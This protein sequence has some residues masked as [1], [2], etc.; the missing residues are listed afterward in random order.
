MFITASAPN[1]RSLGATNGLAQTTVSIARAVGPA[2]SS[3][4]F[5][6]SSQHNLLGGYAVYAVFGGL[7]CAS[8][9]LAKHLPEDA[10]VE[11]EGEDD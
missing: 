9:L 5:A 11:I 3:S 4:I 7:A 6:F 1:K 2:V 8:L 10:S